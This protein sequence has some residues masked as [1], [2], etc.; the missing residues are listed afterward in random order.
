[1]RKGAD[2]VK[3]TMRAEYDFSSMKGGVRGKYAR[4]YRRGTN[5]VLLEPDLALA[6]P[7]DTAVNEALRAVL[8][9]TNAVRRNKAIRLGMESSLP[10]N[11]RTGSA[12]S[13]R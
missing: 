1:M 11:R 5:L 2:R 10:G 8:Q 7:S 12:G 3:N 9:M 4:R 6:F 13:G